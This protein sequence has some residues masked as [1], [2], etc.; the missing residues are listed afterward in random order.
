MTKK[1]LNKRKK[2]FINPAFQLRFIGFS[3]IVSATAMSVFY[4]C[5]YYFFYSLRN[6]GSG[7]GLPVTHSFFTLIQ[8]QQTILNHIFIICALALLLIILVMG[9]IFSH[10]IAGPIYRMQRHMIELSKSK[11]YTD[12]RFR[13]NDFFPELAEA[14]NSLMQGLKK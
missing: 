8:R 5:N 1:S 2:F 3:V 7:F 13:K 4:F 10:R 12:V 9:I 11:N 6:L 14:F